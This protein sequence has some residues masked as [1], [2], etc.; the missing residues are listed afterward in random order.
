MK[1]LLEGADATEIKKL[2]GAKLKHEI[3]IVFFTSRKKGCQYC[4]ETAQ[5]LG[6]ISELSQEKKIKLQVLD[7]EDNPERAEELRIS[8]VP[9]TVILSSNGSPLFYFGMPSGYQLK[10]LIED[11]LD[12]S[13]GTTDLPEE[14]KKLVKSITKPV[15][16][17]IFV[18]P[19]CPYSPSVVHAAHQ[20]AIENRLIRAEMIESL[21]FPD[22]TEKYKVAGVPKTIINDSLSLEGMSSKEVLAKRISEASR[23]L[24]MRQF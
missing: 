5:L 20:F 2:F 16:L 12:A 24:P 9:A 4:N 19:A 23:N 10:C 11:I 3:R 1:P 17:K 21:E 15:N 8:S 14:V 7:L 18:T 6:E 22:L 13:E